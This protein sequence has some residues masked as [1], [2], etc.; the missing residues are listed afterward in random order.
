MDLRTGETRS[1]YLSAREAV[2]AAYLQFEKQNY[3]TWEYDSIE[4]PIVYGK[5]TVA[6]G[7]YTAIRDD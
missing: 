1:Y 7:D 2:K 4:V 6:C 5:H 3:N